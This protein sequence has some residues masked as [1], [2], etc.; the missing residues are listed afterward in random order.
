MNMT[1]ARR[2]EVPLI[3]EQRRELLMRLLHREKVLSVHQLTEMLGVSHMTVRRDISALEG[4][5]RVRAI[6]G[7]VRLATLVGTEP[8]RA[9]KSLMQ[10]PH[11]AAIAR[12]AVRLLRDDMVVYLDAGTTTHALAARLDGLT[13]LTIVT[14]DFGIVEEAGLRGIDTVHV[15]GQVEHENRSSIGIIA[16]TTLRGLNVDLAVISA[17]SWSSRHGVTTPSPGK[18]EVKVAAM[19][20]ASA[21]VLVADSSKY[22]SFSM[23]RV[24]GLQGFSSIVTDDALPAG[25]VDS[26][27]QLEVDLVLAADE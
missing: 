16:A 4:D 9:D 19:E 2:D 11:K 8:S 15:G 12:E 7:G 13:G 25:A 27:R 3:P 20:S 21:S 6:A 24:A 10:A 23:Y 18:V 14:N 5:G 22:G 26:I 17:S 1:S